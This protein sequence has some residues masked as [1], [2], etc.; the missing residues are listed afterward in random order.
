MDEKLSALKEIV[1]ANRDGGSR[2]EPVDDEEEEVNATDSYTRH[3]H[4]VLT[5]LHA[6]ALPPLSCLFSLYS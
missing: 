1:A 4:Y 5:N 6:S 3:M 2:T